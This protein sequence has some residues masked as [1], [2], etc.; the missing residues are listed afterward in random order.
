MGR[1]KSG[2]SGGAGACPRKDIAELLERSG[3]MVS[4][5]LESASQSIVG[6]DQAGRI[7]LANARTQEM[8][9]YAR[10]EMLGSAIEMLL[11][12][13]VRGRH[14]QDRSAYFANPH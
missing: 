2:Q 7:V 10:E 4:A 3:H 12:E 13:A 9:G 6:I 5:L 8:F 11:P 14:A 1:P